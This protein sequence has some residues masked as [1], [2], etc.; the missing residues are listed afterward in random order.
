MTR[1]PSQDVEKLF[2]EDPLGTL[3]QKLESVHEEWGT[4]FEPYKHVSEAYHRIGKDGKLRAKIRDAGGFETE[5]STA[6]SA[7]ILGISTEDLRAYL[8]LGKQC[9]EA[10]KAAVDVEQ[11]KLEWAQ[12]IT[13]APLNELTIGSFPKRVGEPFLVLY[14]TDW[15]MPCQ[16][17]KPTFA[18]L[19]HFFDKAPLHYSFDDA[20]MKQEDVGFIP[21]FV[22]YF[23]D[24]SK[25]YSGCG[26]NTREVWD[27]M[28]KL[29]TL[30]FGFKG[31]GRLECSGEECRINPLD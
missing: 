30:G 31:K 13:S 29:M 28:H 12:L 20:L 17:L 7:E 16:L 5:E 15:C 10:E 24:G 25:V 9:N 23:P 14:T 21:Q 4:K 26:E 6:K 27:T 1:Q 19:S 22:A 2:E 8:A 18:R 11:L 3:G